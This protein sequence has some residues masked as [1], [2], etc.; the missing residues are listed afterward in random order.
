MVSEQSRSR[1]RAFSFLD[2]RIISIFPSYE[3]I[4]Q[5]F[6]DTPFPFPCT[7]LSSEH[8]SPSIPVKIGLPKREKM[9]K[10]YLIYTRGSRERERYFKSGIK[11]LKYERILITAGRNYLVS[12]RESENG[13]KKR[14]LMIKDKYDGVGEERWGGGGGEGTK[15]ERKVHQ[16]D[17]KNLA[18][19]SLPF[20]SPL[21][22]DRKATGSR[23]FREFIHGSRG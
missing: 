7:H 10:R 6:L 14:P 12:C 22:L 11:L 4:F 13:T 19:L 21:H 5:R 15:E 23:K 18:P 9:R 20:L 1:Y 3:L 17:R 8:P 2:L 16:A